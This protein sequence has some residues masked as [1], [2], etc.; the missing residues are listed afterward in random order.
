MEIKLLTLGEFATNCYLLLDGDRGACAIVDP[1]DEG[2]AVCRA[3][4]ELGASPAAILLTHGHFDHLLA[5]PDLQR[6][7][8]EL[9]VYCHRLDWPEETWE[10]YEGAVYPTVTAFPNLRHYGEGDLL[11]IGGLSVR[12]LETPGHTPG[13]VTLQVGNALFTGD[14]LFREDIGRTD[15][16]GGDAAAM[17]RSLDRLAALEGDY[18]VLP[19]H[20][21]VSTLQWERLH[22]PYLNGQTE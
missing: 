8:P 9:S 22:N 21:E 12:V 20:D 1:A 15:F 3:V 7:W 19:G 10:R 17:R 2:A 4:E 13:S 18:R 14:T 16:D 5:V 6:R 11:L